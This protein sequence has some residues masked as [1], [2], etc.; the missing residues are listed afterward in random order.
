MD[1]QNAL[2]DKSLTSQIKISYS[3]TQFRPA[4][5]VT[6][7]VQYS[8]EFSNTYLVFTIN[9]GTAADRQPYKY[10]RYVSTSE[11]G[12]YFEKIT[13]P[14][15]TF[16]QPTGT[17]PT[18]PVYKIKAT[19]AFYSPAG[20][21]PDMTKLLGSAEELVN[22]L[23][24]W[25]TDYYY[26]DPD[27][28]S[29]VTTYTTN[30]STATVRLSYDTPMSYGKEGSTDVRSYRLLLFNNSNSLVQDSGELLN[31]SSGTY[32][33]GFY[34]FTNLKDNSTYYVRG[35]VTLAGGYVLDYGRIP[36]RVNYSD[37]PEYS[38]RF[39]LTSTPNGVKVTLDLSGIA[40]SRVVISRTVYAMSDYLEVADVTSGSNEIEA[41]DHYAIPKT[42]YMYK[43]AVYSGST[44]TA[45]YYNAITYTSGGIK[46]SDILGS[47]YA[48]GN[49]TK[50]PISRN[51]RG[52][53]LETMDS[54]FPYHVMNAAPDYDSGQVDAL[55]A[56]VDD[57]CAIDTDNSAYADILRAWLNNG[58]AKLLTYYNGE[59]WIVTVT[60]IQTTDP[61]N[62]DVY[63]TS[64]NWT[65][66]GDTNKL[67][68]Y[69]R[70]GLVIT[71]E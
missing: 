54:K 17:E 9:Y 46:I 50:H 45:T 60:G 55:F 18:A 37:D 36:L 64:F 44:V 1:E 34:T 35:R 61:E 20:Q 41:V 8:K 65:Q 57:D 33:A 31:W 62:T 11:S 42:M 16:Y 59:S 10:V 14:G 6:F 7:T 27:S 56:E 29:V 3:P 38:D 66:I 4:D 68:E 5:D 24:M 58:H 26:A 15:G 12:T 39:R 22:L 70:L 52:S 32:K 49:I 13:I 28:G 69:V 53:I 2:Y 23:L 48:L 19:A 63:N 47:F 25:D 30:K 43:A 67:S 71:N 40:H 51:D 21:E